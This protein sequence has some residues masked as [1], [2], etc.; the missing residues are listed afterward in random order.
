MATIH[1]APKAMRL[2]ARLSQEQKEM[3]ERAAT[4]QDMTLTEFVVQS[5]QAAAET[6]I[7]NHTIMEL[8]ARDSALLA[9]AL[10][11]PRPLSAG[12]QEALRDHAARVEQA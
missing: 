9:E 12:L 11:T 5:V 2:A 7:H 6:V 4:L 1:K 3:I 10:L 8:T